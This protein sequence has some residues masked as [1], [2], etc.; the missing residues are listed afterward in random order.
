M[1]RY[2]E[3]IEEL[4]ARMVHHPADPEVVSMLKAKGKYRSRKELQKILLMEV[5]KW[6]RETGRL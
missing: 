1:S 6:C 3:S 5:I 4:R 2:E